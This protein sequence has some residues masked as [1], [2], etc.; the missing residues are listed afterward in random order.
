MSLPTELEDI[1]LTALE[2]GTA[3]ERTA[4]LDDA[5]RGQTDL[6][7]EVERLLAAHPQ[8]GDFLQ[9]PP[10]AIANL[11]DTARETQAAGTPTLGF[12]SPS[13]RPGSLVRARR[14]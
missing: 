13:Q 9:S 5:C 6:R 7:Q 4:W 11:A 3:A 10:T 14:R 1:F 12:L 2:K 8:V